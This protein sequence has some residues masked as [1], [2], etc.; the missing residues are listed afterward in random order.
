MTA[1]SAFL[2]ELEDAPTHGSADRRAKTL[3]RVTDLFACSDRAIFPATVL[4]CSIACSIISSPISIRPPARCWP[5]GSKHSLRR[6]A[7]F[8]TLAFDDLYRGRRA[9]SCRVGAHRQRLTGRERIGPRIQD[10]LMAI[11]RRQIWSK[12]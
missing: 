9:G 3:R 1:K 12:P 11:S 8:G 5:I 4:L 10:H 7:W 2:N 6:R